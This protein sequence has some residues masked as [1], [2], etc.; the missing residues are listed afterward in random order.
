MIEYEQPDQL[1]SAQCKCHYQ[2]PY[3]FAPEADCPQH[4][5]TEFLEL[6]AFGERRTEKKEHEK[7]APGRPLY[8]N[9]HSISADGN[10]SMGCC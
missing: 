5:T 10:C 4:D 6:V 9:A 2:E 8:S 7:C 3:G 1:V